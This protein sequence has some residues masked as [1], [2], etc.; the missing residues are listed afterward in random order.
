MSK[1]KTGDY[2]VGR[3]RPP[4][5]T[6]FKKGQS[7]NIAGRPK[8]A[9]SLKTDLEAELRSEVTVTENGRTLKLTKQR[10]FIKSVL[11]RAFKGDRHASTQVVDLIARTMGIVGGDDAAEAPLSAE[12]QEILDAFQADLK[13]KLGI[14][15]DE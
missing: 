3:N 13:R 6:R 12:D 1:P 2:V 5:A 4:I 11:S 10:L 9:V 14:A 8:G 7:G 15:G